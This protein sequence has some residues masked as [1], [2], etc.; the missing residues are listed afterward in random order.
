[1]T[2]VV[3]DHIANGPHPAPNTTPPTHNCEEQSD[4]PSTLA[5]QATPG[6]ESTEVRRA[7]ADLKTLRSLQSKRRRVA[8]LA[9]TEKDMHS[10]SHGASLA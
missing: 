10:R 4:D 9:M 6:S 8:A 2:T 3:R 7:K 1:M 5:A